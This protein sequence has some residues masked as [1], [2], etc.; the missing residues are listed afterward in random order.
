[1]ADHLLLSVSFLV[2]IG[3]FGVI[4]IK[5]ATRPWQEDYKSRH[6][7]ELKETL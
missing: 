5:P 6:L 7:L 1:M 2:M 3:V 4:L